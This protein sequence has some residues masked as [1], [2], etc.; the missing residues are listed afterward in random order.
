MCLKIVEALHQTNLVNST[1]RIFL[2]LGI[3]AV[4]CASAFAKDDANAFKWLSKDQ[5]LALSSSVPPPPAP[6]STEDQADLAKIL[7]V[8]K[9]RTPEMIAE[10]KADQGFSYNLFQSVYGKDLTPEN[11]PKFFQ[12]MKNVLATTQQ[13]NVT[14]KDKYRRLRPYLGHPDVVHSLFTVGG[15]SYP[16]GHSMGSFALATVL[17]AVFP[18]KKQAFL[19]RAAQI[20]QSR[21]D[22]GVHYPSDIKEGEVLGKATGEAILANS[23]FQADLAEVQAELKK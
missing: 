3:V 10:S 13:V 17:G 6:N 16:S 4:F 9:S 1:C 23:A 19:D 8:Q 22:A 7:E 18:D 2:F 12:L 5:E 20:A 14:A 21:V 15:F 11:S